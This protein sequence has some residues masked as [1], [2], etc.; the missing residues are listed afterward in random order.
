MVPSVTDIFC[1][2]ALSAQR[3]FSCDYLLA[4]FVFF[5]VTHPLRFLTCFHCSSAFGLLHLFY[6]HGS[7]FRTPSFYLEN[8]SHPPKKGTHFVLLVLY[9]SPRKICAAPTSSPSE[10]QKQHGSKILRKKKHG[11]KKTLIKP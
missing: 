1:T 9:P 10:I 7:L 3:S 8:K 11:S 5:L 4:S 2:K 6:S